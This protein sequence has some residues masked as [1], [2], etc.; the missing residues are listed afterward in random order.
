M[1]P[2]QNQLLK[3]PIVY[4]KSTNAT[5][6]IEQVVDV[7]IKTTISS[8][9]EYHPG[10]IYLLI[11]NKFNKDILISQV[12]P[13]GPDFIDFVYSKDKITISPHQTQILAIEI[14]TQGQVLPGKHLFLFNIFF[15]W[16][17][18][19]KVKIINLVSFKEINVG[20]IGESEIL[21]LLGVPSLLVLPG[22]LMLVTVKIFWELNN[23]KDKNN[24]FPL[25]T[26]SPEFW[27]I[28]I[29]LSIPMIFL[30]P[31]I[32]ER[33]LKIRRS[34]LETYGPTDVLLVWVSSILLAAALYLISIGSINLYK[35][36]RIKQDAPSP[37]DD[38]VTILYK[39][40][41]QG[42]GVALECVNLKG[43][44]QPVFL[45]ES[46]KDDKEKLWVAP[47]I[48]L[49]WLKGSECKTLREDV[50]NQLTLQGKAK[51]LA[52]LLKK[53]EKIKALRVDWQTG[54]NILKPKQVKSIDITN[55]SKD[56]FVKEK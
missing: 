6:T 40:D 54:S 38:P 51:T 29:T 23:T 34:Y 33:V 32:T 3:P 50:S 21:K 27:F 43:I 13:I 26:I 49:E 36:W 18:L 7:N 14:K 8:L 45:L 56:I 53:G 37:E 2:A 39:L 55:Y 12:C 1:Y 10:K 46:T 17:D 47:P 28:A 48:I 31:I 41:K 4:A 52:N 35:I 15:Q 9:D 25:K 44:E 22:F 5:E 16:K 19:G 24:T 42:L 20:V 30:Y 11:K